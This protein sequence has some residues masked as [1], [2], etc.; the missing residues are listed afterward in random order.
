MADYF[1]AKRTFDAL[2]AFAPLIPTEVLPYLALLLLAST[3]GLAFYFTTLKKEPVP[4][5]E[6]AVASSASLLG[7]FGVVALFCSVGVYV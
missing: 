4:L 5:R 2:P 1:E 3:F 6:L 7:G